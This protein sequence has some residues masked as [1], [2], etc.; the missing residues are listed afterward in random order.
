MAG[1]FECFVLIL[2][3]GQF[4]GC[5]VRCRA[6]LVPGTVGA[7][8]RWCRAPLG[9]CWVAAG[10]QQGCATIGWI[11]VGPGGRTRGA[12][13]GYSS[14]RFVVLGLFAWVVPFFWG[15]GG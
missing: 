12:D 3:V 5:R 6:P 10:W 15:G 4:V 14:G 2:W 7:G 1:W 13:T 8:H 9:R 11:E